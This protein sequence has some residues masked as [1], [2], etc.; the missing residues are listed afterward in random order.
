MKK[1]TIEQLAEKLNGNLWEK[2]DLKR[3]YLDKGHNTKKMSTKTFVFQDENGDFKVSCRVDCP[4]QPWQ[5]CKSQEDEVKE[6]VYNEIESLIEEHTSDN[7]YVL[8]KDGCFIDNFNKPFTPG[9]PLY[10]DDV[11]FSQKTAEAVVKKHNLAAEIKVF[12]KSQWADLCVKYVPE[13]IETNEPVAEARPISAPKKIV[14]TTSP[15]YGVSKRVSHPSFKTGTVIAEGDEVI[16]VEFDDNQ[17][18]TKKL[19]KKFINLQIIE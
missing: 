7:V 10:K 15:V 17:V 1:L 4:S 6:S 19:L 18:G 12:T 16:E 3:I 13:Q 11:Y 2:G 9:N 5:W 8:S 14:N